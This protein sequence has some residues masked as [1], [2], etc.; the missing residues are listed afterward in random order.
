ML[1]VLMCLFCLWSATCV[2]GCDRSSAEPSRPAS[3]AA[4][5][6][7]PAHFEVG[8]LYSIEDG[9]G[10]YRIVKVIATDERFVHLRLYYNH[11]DARPI[12]V[13]PRK[14]RLGSMFPPEA[15]E[16]RNSMSHMPVRAAE[17]IA[18][19]PELLDTRPVTAAELEPYQ[20]WLA[21]GGTGAGTY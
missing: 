18:W 11:F 7:T 3:D 6:A 13:E 21:E 8:G 19:Q 17:L 15:G 20:N 1:R 2:T 4:S 16:Y 12:A 10:G 5:A 9:A 14:L